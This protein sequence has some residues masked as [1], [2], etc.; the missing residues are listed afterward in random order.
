MKRNKENRSLIIKCAVLG[1]MLLLIVFSKLLFGKGDVVTTSIANIPPCWAHP[2]GTDNLGRDLLCRSFIGLRLSLLMAFIMQVICLALGVTIGTVVGYAGGVL[3]KIF[4]FLQNVILSFP[5]TVLT[6]CIMLLLGNGIFSMIVAM[7]IFGWLSYARL[8]RSRVL[9]LREA[10]FIKGEIA[11]GSSLFRIHLFHIVPNVIRTIIPMFTLMIGHAVLGIAGLSFL[12]FGV[13]PPNAE[14]GLMIQDGMNYIRS[15]PWMFIFPG[16]VLAV[17]SIM[18]NTVG[19]ALQDKFD[20]HDSI[21][22]SKM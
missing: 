11:I 14:I 6:L 19:D 1:F 3:D 9:T 5:G 21:N 12:G 16:L 13:Q 7:T 4:V 18:F 15:N 20:P 2:F 8:T 17:Y 10:N 22:A